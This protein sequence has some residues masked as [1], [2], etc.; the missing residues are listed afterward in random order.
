MFIEVTEQPI[1]PEKARTAVRH[2]SCGA[3]ALFE[4]T[5]RVENEGKEV[6]GLEYEAH[7]PL[8]RAEVER[9][10]TE[11]R[12]RW[13]IHQLALLQRTGK[14][15]VGETGIVIAVS[16]PHRREAL[17]ACEYMIE[18]FKKRA[19]VW[20]KEHYADRAAW[21]HCEAIPSD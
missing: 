2:P 21:V 6:R 18:E 16:S 20:K 10:A 7:E 3:I 12:Q 13:P 8:L 4:G 17:A 15:D 5:I 14:L 9:I 19:P 1:D 11:I